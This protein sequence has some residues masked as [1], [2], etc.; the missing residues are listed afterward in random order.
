MLYSAGAKSSSKA[1][2]HRLVVPPVKGLGDCCCRFPSLERL[3]YLMP[4]LRDSGRMPHS[5]AGFELV[6]SPVHAPVRPITD[7]KILPP[8]CAASIRRR[9]PRILVRGDRRSLGSARSGLRSG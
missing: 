7:G 8:R 4:S 6:G 1:H 5:F 3:G 9:L 2:A